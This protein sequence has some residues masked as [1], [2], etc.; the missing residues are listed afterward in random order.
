MGW[1]GEGRQREALAQGPRL[2]VANPCEAPK[3]PRSPCTNSTKPYFQMNKYLAVMILS[4]VSRN[5]AGRSATNFPTFAFVP[6]WA[7]SRNSKTIFKAKLKKLHRF[8]NISMILC[9]TI[10][11]I[12]LHL[13]QRNLLPKRPK[14]LNS[15]RKSSRFGLKWLN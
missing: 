7:V 2:S 15:G 9:P 6:S 11:R 13:K 1:G 4:R 14:S 12:S 5:L 8:L 10:Q 3:A